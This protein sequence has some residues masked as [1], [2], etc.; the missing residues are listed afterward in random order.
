[1]F[2]L[3]LLPLIPDGFLGLRLRIGKIILLAS[4]N[5]PSLLYYFQPLEFASAHPVTA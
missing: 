3:L 4:S 1:M 2:P 5:A